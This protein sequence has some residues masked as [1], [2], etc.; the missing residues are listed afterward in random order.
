MKIKRFIEKRKKENHVQD[1][2]ITWRYCCVYNQKNIIEDNIKHYLMKNIS[3]MIFDS[4]LNYYSIEEGKLCT[5]K[6]S[7]ECEW[8]TI[9]GHI[10]FEPEYELNEMEQHY[11]FE[12]AGMLI[13]KNVMF[14]NKNAENLFYVVLEPML[15][16]YQF[17]QLLMY[18]LIKLCDGLIMVEFR[19]FPGNNLMTDDTFIDNYSTI[20]HQKIKNIKIDQNL[21][22]YLYPKRDIEETEIVEHDGYKQILCKV[23][24]EEFLYQK[25]IALCLLSLFQGGE[26]IDWIERTTYSLNYE[27]NTS[28]KFQPIM[29]SYGTKVNFTE[30]IELKDYRELDDYS[31]YVNAGM[32][33]TI[34]E[35]K[36]TYMFAD[37]LDEEL[38]FMITQSKKFKSEFYQNKE[39]DE[40][41]LLNLYR[42]ILV[43]KESYLSKYNHLLQVKSI[44]KDFWVELEIDELLNIVQDLLNLQIQEEEF[45]KNEY[46][47]YLQW[48]IAIVT[49]I[50]SSSPIYE[51]IVSPIYDIVSVMPENNNV[52]ISLYLFSIA[53][54]LVIVIIMHK[55]IRSQIQKQSNIYNRNREKTIMP[56]RIKKNEIGVGGIFKLLA[57]IITILISLF[58][59]MIGYKE[60]QL[61][62]NQYILSQME[63]E[64]NEREKQPFFNI[65]REYDEQRKQYIYSVLNTGGEVRYSDLYLEPYMFV[66]VYSEEDINIDNAKKAF[67]KIPGVFQYEDVTTDEVLFEFSDKWIDTNLLGDHPIQINDSTTVLVN[68]Y[69]NHLAWENGQILEGEWISA[70][71]VYHLHVSYYDYKNDEKHEEYWYARSSDISENTSG[72]NVLY[73]QN[74]MQQWYSEVG[75]KGNV[76]DIDSMNFS[77]EETLKKCDETM[78]YF[79]NSQN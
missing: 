53:I 30:K 74:M 11:L 24:S 2:R 62:N 13:H 76:Y 79:I 59:T 73:I 51:Y 17:I 1:Y 54:S 27:D 38:L 60:Y 63:I 7:L 4:E 58:A 37:C 70:N 5:K 68:D 49:I 35:I 56:K 36:D 57:S 28:A 22:K 8:G 9:S 23:P 50:L 3:I 42:K 61:K 43:F 26:E 67:V 39:L 19:V 69:L 20:M 77:L 18:P 52:K 40:Q 6:F 44:V 55:M 65:S 64:K 41:N 66:V 25:D 32:S 14:D 15:V 33:M 47:N 10:D 72:N 48:G 45:R 71:I 21:Y 46:Q 12:I 29:F 16:Q 34:G 75:E 31:H 78:E